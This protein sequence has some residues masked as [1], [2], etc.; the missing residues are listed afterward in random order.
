M[1][2]VFKN[3]LIGFSAF[4]LFLFWGWCAIASYFSI[5][6]L[7]P[8]LLKTLLSWALFLSFFVGLVFF[9]KSLK[10]FFI[11][12]LA[13]GC[14][15]AI[16]YLW[17]VRPSNQRD[18]EP[19]YAVL[20]YAE[21]NGNLVTVH[22]IRDFD[23]RS[24][25][26]FT[27]HYYDKT[28]DLD[29]LRSIDYI[30]SYWDGNKDVAHTITSYGFEDGSYLASSIET[31]RENGEPQTALRGLFRQY[32][33][34]YVLADER[35]ILR[36]RTDFRKEQ[37][38][39]YPL[40]GNREDIKRLFMEMIQKVNSLYKKPEFYDTITRNCLTSFLNDAYKIHSPEKRFDI[41]RLLNGLSA[42]M[43]YENGNIDTDL[44]FEETQK[45]CHAN[46]YLKGDYN[47]NDYSTLIR[48]EKERL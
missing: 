31:R 36:L 20:P 16:C 30:L 18:W 40:R 13:V 7:L 33:I 27:P 34:I 2:T 39:V 43:I 6:S 38:Y 3:I 44:S 1:K 42:E 10:R 48:R 25:T 47:V 46:Q 26:D 8:D 41:R 29:K 21:I 24:E 35:D 14:V 28:F 9:R 22:N 37:V 15:L 11:V 5:F 23:Y 45:K 32:E 12:F 19:E 4:L 17:G